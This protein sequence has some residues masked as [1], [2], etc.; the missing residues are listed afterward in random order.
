[1]QIPRSTPRNLVQWDEFL[2]AP[3]GDTAAPSRVRTVT[4][5]HLVDIQKL[6]SEHEK[7]WGW[8]NNWKV[9]VLFSVF[10]TPGISVLLFDPFGADPV[11]AG[12]L[13]HGTVLVLMGTW[14]AYVWSLQVIKSLL[15][16]R[17]VY[18]TRRNVQPLSEVIGACEQALDLVKKYPV[19]RAYRDDV[20]AQGRA[21][22]VADLNM[23][24]LL[25]SSA[26]EEEGAEM[27]E[28]FCRELHGVPS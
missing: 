18:W 13:L 3:E 6:L 15:R 16:H 14:L 4:A 28:R 9:P 17:A 7:R 27:H 23:L 20:V 22:M 19:C 10:A 25:A 12:M 26:K 24:E 21:L 8:T 1:M 2:N 5:Q 11:D